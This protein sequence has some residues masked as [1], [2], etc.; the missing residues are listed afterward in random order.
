MRHESHDTATLMH[1][2]PILPRPEWQ[3]LGC[4]ARMVLVCTSAARATHLLVR[5]SMTEDR[6]RE[7]DKALSTSSIGAMH[8]AR[9]RASF[10]LRRSLIRAVRAWASCTQREGKRDTKIR[11]WANEMRGWG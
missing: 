6:E 10:W 11:E 7:V 1:R 2:L 4:A 8:S 5:M 9:D 3:M